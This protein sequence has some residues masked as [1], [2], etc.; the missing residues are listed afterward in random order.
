[1]FFYQKVGKWVACQDVK[2]NT[3]IDVNAGEVVSIEAVVVDG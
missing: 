3:V 1:M 2:V